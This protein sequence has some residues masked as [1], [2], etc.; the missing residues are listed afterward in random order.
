MDLMVSVINIINSL[1]INI[2]QTASQLFASHEGRKR[3]RM[4]RNG[5]HE[6]MWKKETP[7]KVHE[8]YSDNAINCDC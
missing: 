6:I 3:N 4:E 8:K 2:M 7:S 1:K 5:M